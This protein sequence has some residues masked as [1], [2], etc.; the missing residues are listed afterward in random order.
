M[1]LYIWDN[2]IFITTRAKPFHFDLP[3]DV[4]NDMMHKIEYTINHQEYLA[5]HK[6]KK[7][8]YAIIVQI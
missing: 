7:R 4:D 1:G 8:D 6:I 5:E 2:K 3:R